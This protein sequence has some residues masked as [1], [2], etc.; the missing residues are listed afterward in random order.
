MPAKYIFGITLAQNEQEF[1]IRFYFLFD[2][3]W[4]PS[5]YLY[6]IRQS[7]LKKKPEP[8]QIKY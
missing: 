6:K 1:N 7:D 5:I 3:I 2:L 4:I 8:N